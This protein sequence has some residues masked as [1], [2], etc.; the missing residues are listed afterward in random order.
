M[1]IATIEKRSSACW[2]T[3]EIEQASERENGGGPG[4]RGRP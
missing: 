1:H 2:K 4:I 3:G